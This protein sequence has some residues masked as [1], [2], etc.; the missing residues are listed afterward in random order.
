MPSAP[1]A[2]PL[3]GQK[4]VN[5]P[6]DRTIA[7]SGPNSPAPAPPKGQLVVMPAEKPFD[8]YDEAQQSPHSGDDARHP[9]RMFRPAPEMN[10]VKTA[11]AAGIAADGRAAGEGP[12][13]P[14]VVINGAE[15]MNGIF[16]LDSAGDDIGYSAF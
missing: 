13:S 3:V 5:L 16:A 14:E 12:Y 6:D 2:A 10:D 15:F 7:P 8:P 9:E 1:G 4:G 11:V